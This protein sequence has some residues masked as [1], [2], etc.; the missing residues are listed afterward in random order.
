MKGALSAAAVAST[1]P[2]VLVFA[3]VPTPLYAWAVGRSV[4]RYRAS[5]AVDGAPERARGPHGGGHVAS[6]R[7]KRVV[8]LRALRRPRGALSVGQVIAAVQLV[9]RV[10]SP[11]GAAGIRRPVARCRGL[12]RAVMPWR[13]QARWGAVRDRGQG[14][15]LSLRHGRPPAAGWSHGLMTDRDDLGPHLSD[16]G[17]YLAMWPRRPLLT[18]LAWIRAGSS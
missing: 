14:P 11:D 5:V 12:P 2:L 7:G 1:S 15:L 9:A 4:R 6:L 3:L 8:R 18:R 17:C 16:A 10:Y 13:G